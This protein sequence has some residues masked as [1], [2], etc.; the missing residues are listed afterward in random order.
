MTNDMPTIQPSLRDFMNFYLKPGN[1]QS[2]QYKICTAKRMLPGYF[3]FVPSGLHWED[4]PRL[5]ESEMRPNA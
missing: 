5:H 3:R 4:R 1:K 2:A